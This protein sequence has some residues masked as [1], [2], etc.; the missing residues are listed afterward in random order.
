LLQKRLGT[1]PGSASSSGSTGAEAAAPPTS[2]ERT[3]KE[4]LRDLATT[5]KTTATQTGGL[6]RVARLPAEGHKAEEERDLAAAV[7]AY[8]LAMALAPE[9]LEIAETHERLAK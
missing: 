3:K 9:R 8:R 6:D 1:R 4:V 5:L 2:V 7:R